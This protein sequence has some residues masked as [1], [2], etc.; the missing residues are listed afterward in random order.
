MIDPVVLGLVSG[1]SF[2]FGWIACWLRER[3]REGTTP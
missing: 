3:M 1:V 2:A